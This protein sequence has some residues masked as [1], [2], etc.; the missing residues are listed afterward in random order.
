MPKL[1]PVYPDSGRWGAKD[2]A[3]TDPYR[4]RT[5]ATATAGKVSMPS[6]FNF[7]PPAAGAASKS[8]DWKGAVDSV[9]PFV[10]NIA[11][12]F[13]RPPMPGKYKTLSPVRM[14]RVNMNADRVEVAR[15]VA[16]A[17]QGT[18]A[19]P[20]NEAAALRTAN[21]IQGIRGNNQ[22]TQAENNTNV[23]IAN[24]EAM[25]NAQ[26][27]VQNTGMY[28]QYQDTLVNRNMVQQTAQSA[29]LANAADKYIGIQNE[30]AQRELD[31][32][33]FGVLSQMYKPSGVLDRL[34]QGTDT[35]YTKQKMGGTIRYGKMKRVYSGG[36]ELTPNGTGKPNT[37]S[38]PYSQTT[39]ADRMMDAM[40]RS[41]RGMMLMNNQLNIA[42]RPAQTAEALRSGDYFGPPAAN[43]QYVTLNNY[44]KPQVATP[45]NVN[46]LVKKA[47]GGKLR[48][49]C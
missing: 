27:D 26:I 15:A 31:M 33:K 2:F 29:N 19:L 37:S 40:V 8:M 30:R 21:L 28:N 10:S 49:V 5:S 41:Q 13:R 4:P 20:E 7:T 14:G 45:V 6:A 34:L 9:A 12:S 22:I 18:R 42:P 47:M 1:K 43:H 16:G 36:G 48:K 44:P 35:P 46:T 11:N 24:Q 17:N 38:V 25:A 3:E 23:G 32:Q 39:E